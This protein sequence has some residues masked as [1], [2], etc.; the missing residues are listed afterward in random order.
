MWRPEQTTAARMAVDPR[1]SPGVSSASNAERSVRMAAQFMTVRQVCAAARTGY[2]G[3][4]G[5][6]AQCRLAECQKARSLA[7]DETGA[8]GVLGHTYAVSGNRAEALKVLSELKDLSQRRYVA[9]FENALIYVGLGDKAQAFEWLER[10]Y[11]DHSYRLAW[12]KVDPRFDSLHGEPPFH[13]LLRRM[14][15]SE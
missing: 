4:V 15:L 8:L 7:A 11:G 13:D 3:S 5:G 12:I 14:R 6:K 9:P 1:Q 10:A 2:G